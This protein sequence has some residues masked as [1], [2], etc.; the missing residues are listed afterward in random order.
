MNVTELTDIL[1]KALYD[2][3]IEAQCKE[4]GFTIQ[5]EPDAMTSWC[6]NCE[7]VVKVRNPLISLGL[8]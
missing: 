5:C 8:I 4:C 1:D 6:D 7:K 2:G 3:I